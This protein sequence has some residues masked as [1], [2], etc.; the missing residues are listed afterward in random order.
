MPP[1]NRIAD[2]RLRGNTSPLPIRVY[3]P[4][5]PVSHPVPLLVFCIVG[6]GSDG[7][8]R[9]RGVAFH[10][11]RRARGGLGTRG[12]GL[13]WGADRNAHR[14]HRAGRDHAGVGRLLTRHQESLDR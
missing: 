7:L 11:G 5:Q 9:G 12:P 10:P 13:R 3:W 14:A 2:M 1:I 4:G 8:R 6:A